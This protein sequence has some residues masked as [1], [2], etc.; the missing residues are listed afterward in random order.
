MYDGSRINDEDTPASLGMEDNGQ[1]N[2]SSLHHSLKSFSLS[3]RHPDSV[4][5]P[6]HTDTIDVMVERPWF[7]LF[8]T[9]VCHVL[10]HRFEQ[11]SEGVDKIPPHLYVS[12]RRL[13][14]DVPMPYYLIFPP[15]RLSYLQSH[16]KR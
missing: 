2:P 11:R 5:F 15:C 14:I 12:H 6:G 4:S 1:S 10:T 16:P 9:L 13:V 7:Y 3:L 8:A